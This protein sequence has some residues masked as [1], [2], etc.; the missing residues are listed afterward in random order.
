L[1]NNGI[2][3]LSTV[4][5]EHLWQITHKPKGY[6]N[7]TDNQ[8]QFFEQ[9]AFQLNIQNPDDW[10]S[11]NLRTV[12]KLGGSFL[13]SHYDGSL[14]R[15]IILRHKSKIVALRA[16]YPSH[17][18]KKPKQQKPWGHWNSKINQRVFLDQLATKLNIQKPEDWYS[19]RPDT[20]KTMGGS[21]VY[22]HYNGSLIEGT[23]TV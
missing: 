13:Y 8:R 14:I 23:D 20:V 21:F 22:T 4:Y 1:Y 11:V 16:L 18:W 12:V 19:I 15:G 7:D 10:Y 17:K 3:A 5:P 2:S 6:W 9:L